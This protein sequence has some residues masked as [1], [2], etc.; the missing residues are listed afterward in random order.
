[1]SRYFRVVG[2]ARRALVEG[3]WAYRYP[4]KVSTSRSKAIREELNRAH[5]E[6]TR[7]AVRPIPSASPSRLSSKNRT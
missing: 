5:A 4:A 1:L 3:A 2:H 7:P 6:R